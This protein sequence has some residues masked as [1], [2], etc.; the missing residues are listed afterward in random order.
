MP[1]QEVLTR[2]LFLLR[3]I[4]RTGEHH[5][6]MVSQFLYLMPVSFRIGYEVC[7]I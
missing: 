1:G 4:Q 3:L 5:R 7:L 2:P 6:A